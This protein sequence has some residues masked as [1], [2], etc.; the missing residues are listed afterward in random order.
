MK[1]SSYIET[2][3]CNKKSKLHKNPS[4]LVEK[5]FSFILLCGKMIK[6]TAE[7]PWRQGVA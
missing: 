3:F 5:R 4:N 7:R 6:N 2:Q 1:C